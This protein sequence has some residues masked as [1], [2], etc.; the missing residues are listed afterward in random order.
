M[1]TNPSAAAKRLPRRLPTLRQAAIALFIALQLSWGLKALFSTAFLPVFARMGFIGA[2]FL[3]AFYAT[4]RRHPALRLLSIAL[5][6]PVASFATFVVAEWPNVGKY[7]EKVEGAGAFVVLTLVSW[8]CGL[9]SASIALRFERKA[10]EREER[11]R[12][13]SEK[14][15]LERSLLDARLRLLQAQIEPHFLFNTLANVQALV[16]A[17]SPNAAPVLRHLINYLRAAGPHLADADA[18]LGRELQLVEAYL[19]LMRMRMPDRLEY[20]LSVAPDLADLRF[21]AM[22]LLTLVENA[23]RHGIDP[24]TDGGR[25][26]VG[27]ARDGAT[28]AVN[29][30]VQDTGA[31]MPES[32]A[33]GAGLANVRTRL[34]ATFGEAARLDLHEVAPHGLRAECH[35]TAR[36]PEC[37][38]SLP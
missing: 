35:F 11:A 31:G 8:I 2:V 22:A 13:A 30:W 10:R 1:L 37:S 5:L 33:P 32:A 15:A 3:F 20:T 25:I 9:V 38:P 26:D 18:T 6:A 34:R 21:P 4:A 14:D 19:S 28:G 29:V 16:E 36:E 27:A 7:L 17:G 23:V 12:V 24:T